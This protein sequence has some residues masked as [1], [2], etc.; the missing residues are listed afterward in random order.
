MEY[1]RELREELN[2]LLIKYNYLPSEIEKQKI[3]EMINDS[4]NKNIDINYVINFLEEKLKNKINKKELDNLKTLD[5][6]KYAEKTLNRNLTNE[7]I[8]EMIS[9]FNLTKEKLDKSIELV[10]SGKFEELQELIN[11]NIIIADGFIFCKKRGFIRLN[12][13]IAYDIKYNNI[14]LHAAMYDF[15]PLIRELLKLY[16]KKA[17]EKFNKLYF[18]SIK[19]ALEKCKVLLKNNLSLNGVSAISFL[20]KKYPEMFKDNNMKVGPV[21]EEMARKI[22][23]D[24]DPNSIWGAYIS[25]EEL[26]DLSKKY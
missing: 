23:N 1:E 17:K 14:Q 18:D 4:K 19:G 12:N 8:I 25:R 9:S 3:E 22:F 21:S 10:N 5:F 26:L 11:K 16:G 2:R 13:F 20:V 15:H 7:E 6:F 24:L